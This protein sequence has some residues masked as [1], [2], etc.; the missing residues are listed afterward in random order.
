[1]PK[2]KTHDE[3]VAQVAT[4]NPNI[5]VLGNYMD[6]MT[7]ILHK[8]KIDGYEWHVIPNSILQGTGCPECNRREQSEKYTKTHA[9]YVLEVS[10]LNPNIEVVGEY[11]G[12]EIPI[13]HKCKI[14]GYEW[15]TKPSN[16]LNGTGCPRCVKCEKYGHDEYVRRVSKINPNIEVIGIYI[17]AKTKI[18]HRCKI[19][20][21][22]W[23]AAPYH[24]LRGAGCPICLKNKRTKT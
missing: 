17:D 8:C 12:C 3:Y 19:D 4:I 2:K 20:G 9:Q 24:I 22:N 23:Y 11:V 13:L 1:M 21:H 10:K 14:D 16:I 15:M 6:S 7:K 5:E 18:L